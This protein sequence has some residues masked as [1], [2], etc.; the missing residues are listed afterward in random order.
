MKPTTKLADVPDALEAFNKQIENDEIKADKK[1]LGLTWR[2]LE[3]LEILP[4]EE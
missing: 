3:V 4:R 1:Q 2:E